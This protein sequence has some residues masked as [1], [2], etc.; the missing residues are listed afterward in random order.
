MPGLCLWLVNQTRMK[1]C[2][3][4]NEHDN[5]AIIWHLFYNRRVLPTDN[6]TYRL[7]KRTYSVLHYNDVIIRAMASQITSLTIVYSNVYSGAEQRKHQSS[8]SLAFG[9][10]IHRWSVNSPHKGPVMRKMIPFDD[11]IMVSRGR[12][13]VCFTYSASFTRNFIGYF[14]QNNSY[15]DIFFLLTLHLSCQIAA[16]TKSWKM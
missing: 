6:V 9:W 4:H 14:F 16:F 5:Y 15:H 13:S 11:V 12:S 3:L 2:V 7:L 1:L 8:E 10:G